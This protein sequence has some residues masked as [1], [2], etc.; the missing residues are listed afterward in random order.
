MHSASPVNI[1]VQNHA[2]QPVV[3][4]NLIE[5]T[6]KPTKEKSTSLAT[7]QKSTTKSSL[8]LNR[9]S[10]KKNYLKSTIAKKKEIVR[11]RSLSPKNKKSNDDE[12]NKSAVRINHQGSKNNLDELPVKDLLETKEIN[13]LNDLH[14]NKNK[15]IPNMENQIKAINAS[16]SNAF[17]SKI[18]NNQRIKT[19]HLP[20]QYDYN[21]DLTFTKRSEDITDN[22]ITIN[23]NHENLLNKLVETDIIGSSIAKQLSCL[24]DFLKLICNVSDCH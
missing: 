2:R 10:N 16:S 17:F 11:A 21:K 23:V 14:I 22:I 6:N 3:A 19:A 12:F 20:E 5:E 24:K 13:S 15:Q 1:Y 7:T 18:L 4:T 8:E 9:K